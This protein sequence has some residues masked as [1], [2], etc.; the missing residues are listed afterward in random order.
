VSEQFIQ[1]TTCGR[2]HC[3]KANPFRR[4]NRSPEVMRLVVMRC[5]K[6]PVLLRNVEDLLFERG[7]DI[8]QVGRVKPNS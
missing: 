1:S 3:R 4:F 6:Y 8:C 2:V 5:V 7:I